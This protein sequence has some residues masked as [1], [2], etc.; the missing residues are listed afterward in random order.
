MI[1][2]A[3][4]ALQDVLEIN[5]QD[6]F[7]ILT[8]THCKSIAEAF[9]QAAI[10]KGCKVEKFEIDESKRPLK[11]V[12]KELEKLLPGKTVVLN[13][14]KAFAEEI[15]FRIKWIFKVEENKQIRM[16][17]MPGI[18]EQMMLDSVNVNYQEMR[19]RADSL[20]K[21]LDN[22]SQLHITTEEGTDVML[23]I[24]D[25][26]FVS[27]VGVKQGEM[28]NLPCGEIYC[29]PIESEADGVVLFNASVGDVGL[30]KHPLIIFLSKGIITK[31]ESKD[32]ELVK[33][34]NELQSVDEYAMMIGELG[35]G[36]NPKAR[37]TGNML[38]DEKAIGTAHIAFGNNADFPG[39]GNNKSKI[40]RDYLFYRPT[41][42]V[43]YLDKSK[44][45][46]IRRGEF[47]T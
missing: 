30:L 28:C 2:A 3:S 37:I 23:G 43:T 25:R 15:P 14:I 44:R 17:H 31:F 38:E 45:V 10:N 24:K 1:E 5:A 12:P 33:R 18:T 40:H 27:D 20:C 34:I 19:S 4:G 39:G 22:A 13:I 36:I 26:T 6:D 16:G 7:L 9:K 21:L 35:I 11:D 46:V 47:T 8:D 29:A 42:E 41:I 32:V